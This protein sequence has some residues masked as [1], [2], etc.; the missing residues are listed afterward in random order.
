MALSEEEEEL[1][2]NVGHPDNDGDGVMG[3]DGRYESDTE[4]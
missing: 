3:K 2:K 1:M 4:V